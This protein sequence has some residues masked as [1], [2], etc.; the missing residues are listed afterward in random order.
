MLRS[1]GRLLIQQHWLQALTQVRRSP[2]HGSHNVEGSVSKGDNSRNETCLAE[3]AVDSKTSDVPQT[4]D[5][6]GHGPDSVSDDTLARSA[7]PRETNDSS[8]RKGAHPPADWYKRGVWIDPAIIVRPMLDDEP[9][10]T[11]LPSS[12]PETAVGRSL[13][14]L[15]KVTPLS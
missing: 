12:E 8:Q 6:H 2:Q 15:I 1:F 9:A 4:T 14:A 11:P 5:T 13:S 7:A 3:H 10:D